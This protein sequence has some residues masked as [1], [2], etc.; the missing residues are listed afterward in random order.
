VLVPLSPC[1]TTLL[2]LVDTSRWCL[3]REA[4]LPLLEVACCPPWISPVL[5]LEKEE[6]SWA[7][8]CLAEYPP[9]RYL[10]LPMSASPAQE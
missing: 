6:R 7:Y 10:L 3:L 1:S 9:S 2:K 4:A 5:L 8:R